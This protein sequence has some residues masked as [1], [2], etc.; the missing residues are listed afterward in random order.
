[1]TGAGGGGGK[2]GALGGGVLQPASHSAARDVAKCFLEMRKLNGVML[3]KPSKPWVA[4]CHCTVWF[5]Q[6]LIES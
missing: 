5:K 4:F 2:A 1:L 6:T 3:N